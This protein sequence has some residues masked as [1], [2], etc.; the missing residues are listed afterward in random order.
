MRLV[1]VGTYYVLRCGD[2]ISGLGVPQEVTFV[3]LCVSASGYYSTTPHSWLH[4]VKTWKPRV[5]AVNLLR[6]GRTVE[7]W[8]VMKNLL[9]VVSLREL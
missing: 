4:S 5:V 1:G 7:E 6:K 2:G 3:T 9:F 8:T